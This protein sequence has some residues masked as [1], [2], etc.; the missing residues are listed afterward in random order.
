[1]PTLD[2][3]R[4]FR[5]PVHGY[6]CVARRDIGTDEVIAEVEGILYRWEDVK[7]DTYCLWVDDDYYFDMVDQTRWIN[8]SCEPNAEVFAELDGAGGAWARIVAIRPIKAGEEITYH[9]GFSANVAEPCACGTPSCCGWI[10]DP[11]E[12]PVLMERL[13][14]D[15]RQTTKVVKASTRKASTAA[16]LVRRAR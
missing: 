5:S 15:Q 13:A 14:R 2:N 6:G 10:V 9:Y 1:M 11:D 16:A 8:H 4:V 3:V 12:L 7:D